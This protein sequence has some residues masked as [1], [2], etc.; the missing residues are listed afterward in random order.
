MNRLFYLILLFLLFSC[1]KQDNN[2]KSARNISNDLK[3][4]KKEIYYICKG[5]FSKRYHL[6]KN[7][8]G[9]S[10]CSTEIYEVSMQEINKRGR[11]LC[12]FED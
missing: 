11:T 5:K 9:L 1:N 3:E 2:L 10:N 8:M 7:C 6:N 4:Q 12:G